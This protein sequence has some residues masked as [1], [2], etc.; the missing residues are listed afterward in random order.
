MVS[1]TLTA[2]LL[3]LP[4]QALALD[5]LVKL[6]PG[7]KAASLGVRTVKTLSLSHSEFALVRADD[8]ARIEHHPAVE[9]IERDAEYAT[10]VNEKEVWSQLA[11]AQ[12]DLASA[13]H[14]AAGAQQARRDLAALQ[15]SHEALRQELMA[16]LEAR[17]CQGSFLRAETTTEL[18]VH[19]EHWL[20]QL[21]GVSERNRP[22]VALAEVGLEIGQA[23]LD[24]CGGHVFYSHRLEHHVE[25]ADLVLRHHVMLTTGGRLIERN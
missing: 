12:R 22:P 19:L 3:V 6:R 14:E 23:R 4:L 17:L 7:L 21:L 24:V 15:S 2:A 16:S 9:Y 25:L 18:V 13:R 10:R 11:A 8:L 1:R 5:Y 20:R